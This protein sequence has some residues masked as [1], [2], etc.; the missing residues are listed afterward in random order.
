MDIN[1]EKG[2][3]IIFGK[4]SKLDTMVAKF[5]SL[6]GEQVYSFF[7]NRGIQLPRKINV[8]ALYSVLNDRIKWINSNTLPKDYFTRLKYYSYFTEQQLYNLFLSICNDEESFSEYRRNLFRLILINFVALDLKDGELNYVKTLKKAKTEPFEQYFNFVSGACLEQEDT[9]DGVNT[10]ILR[11]YLPLSASNQEIVDIASKYG[12]DLPTRLSKEQYA[13]Y[14]YDQ[15]KKNNTYSPEI[16]E[17][18]DKM[19]L[20]QL[21]T[22]AKRTN[23]NMEPQMS[24]EQLV[25]YL[26]WYLEQCTISKTTVRRIE[27][28]AIYDPISFEVDLG[29]INIFGNGRGKRLIKYD[30]MYEDTKKWEAIQDGTYNKPE[31]KKIVEEIIDEPEEKEA[32]EEKIKEE[33]IPN[34]TSDEIYQKEEPKKAPF[35][36]DINSGLDAT[37]I[38]GDENTLDSIVSGIKEL[39]EESRLKR[40]EDNKPLFEKQVELK[41]EV[42]LFNEVKE[43]KPEIKK[44]IEKDTITQEKTD[45][46]PNVGIKVIEKKEEIKK[47]EIKKESHGLLVE[48]DFA[49]TQV[50]ENDKYG[51][52]AILGI[53][54][55][56]KAKIVLSIIAL[57][58]VLAGIG[59]LV[60]YFFLK[61]K[62]F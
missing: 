34:K 10:D 18:L 15:M 52:D 38:H 1:L 53:D 27:N 9:F 57:L 5:S 2:T 29:Q 21:V 26:F 31:E 58:I 28:E 62:M 56:E 48:E 17:E 8:L 47:E 42:K 19:S 3:I 46:V 44:E 11:E 43:E 59:F 13:F 7:T 14:I 45:P 24:K 36:E 4:S 60:Y 51:S 23:I 22:Y 12:I 41:E 33:V 30:G 54:K 37:T 55:N 20:Q 16:Q 35:E 40:P 6:S 32:I 61:D 50:T 25:T 39:K 49:S